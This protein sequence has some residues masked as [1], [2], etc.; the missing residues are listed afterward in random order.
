MQSPIPTSTE[1]RRDR[2][3]ALTTQEEEQEQT[4]QSK[5][6]IS[7]SPLTFNSL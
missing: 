5:S 7:R 3:G 4:T 6:A 1:T 2:R